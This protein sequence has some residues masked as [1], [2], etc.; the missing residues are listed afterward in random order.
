LPL[1]FAEIAALRKRCAKSFCA[2]I[3]LCYNGSDTLT[4]EEGIVKKPRTNDDV[5]QLES[6]IAALEQLLEERERERHEQVSHHERTLQELRASQ[7]RFE[8]VMQGTNDGIW[9]WNVLTN[10]VYFSPRWK[11]MLGYED[12]EIQNHFDEWEKRLHPADRERALA[13]VQDY[14]EGRT[15]SYELE[16]R[17]LHKDGTYRW[18]LAR[19]VALRDESGKPYRMAGSHV[20][21]TER[22]QMEEDLNRFFALSI[23]MLCIAG[24]DGYFKRLNPAWEKTLGWTNETMLA[25]PYME[26]VHP[27]DREATLAAARKIVDAGGEVVLFENRYLCKDGSY[28]WLVWNAAPLAGQQMIYAVAHDITE[29]KQAEQT[30]RESETRYRQIVEN[31][32]DVI[33][34]ADVYGRFTYANPVALRIIGYPETELMG[35]HYLDIVRPDYRRETERFYVKQL[36]T[37]TL[38]TYYE[39]P[40]ITKDG[41]EIWLGQN[42]QLVREKDRIVGVQSVARDITERRRME[43]ALRESQALYQSLVETLP[44]HI[45]CKDRDG[46]FTF[47]NKRWC[48]RKGRPIEDIVGK[49]DFDFHPKELAEKY[50]R[51]DQRVLETGTVL[52]AVEEQYALSGE[53][54]YIHILKAPIVND[55]GEIVGTQGM[56]WDVTERRRAEEALRASEERRR[57]IVESAYDAFIAMDADGLIIDWNP[58]AESTFGWSREEVLGRS[59]AETIIPPQHRE[60]HRRGLE[61]FLTTGKGHMTNQRIETTALHRAGHEFPVELTITPIRWGE[62]YI[63]SSFVHDIT[64]RKQ[65]EEELRKAKEAAEAANRAKSD[66]L[67]NVSHEIRTP[68]NGIIGMTELTLDTQLTP[69]QREYLNMVRESADSL[70][71]IINALLDFSKIEAGKLDLE[72]IEF[73]LRDSL[74]DTVRTLALRAHAKGLE[75]VCHVL[76]DVPDALVGDPGRLRQIV[77]NLV[78]NAIKFT[79]KG[80]V[81]VRAAVEGN[82]STSQWGNESVNLLTHELIDPLTHELVDPLTSSEVCLHFSVHDTGIGIPAEKQRLIFEAFTQADS[83]T[84][85]KYGGTGLGLTI[86]SQLVHMMRGRIWV[87]SAEGQGSVFHFTARFGLQQGVAQSFPPEP[88]NL[89]DLPV[90]VVDDNATNCRILGEILTNWRMKPTVVE[91]GAS[92]LAAM[93]EAQKAGEPFALV[94]LD[95]NMPEMDGFA[96]I[97]RIRQNAELDG[98]TIMMLSSADRSG[99]AARCRALGATYL[100]KPIKQSDLLDAVLTALGAASG[101]ARLVGKVVPLAD[102]PTPITRRLHVLLAEDHPVNQRL[103]TFMLEK[104]GHQVVV[105]G[106]GREALEA[107]ERQP[108]DVVLMDVHMPEMDGFAATAAIREKEKTT[109]DRV[110]II[111]MTAMVMKGDRERCLAVGMD[112]YVSKPLQAQELLD[113][114]ESASKPPGEINLDERTFSSTPPPVEMDVMDRATLMYRVG[115]SVELLK[116]IVQ[117]FLA[118]CPKRLSQ[119]REAVARGDSTALEHAAHAL[120]GSLGNLSAEAA[121]S[122]ASQLEMLAHESNVTRYAEAG[123]ALE[124]EVERLQPALE[125]LIKQ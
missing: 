56:Y 118:D 74:G 120:K 44:V 15:S 23:D 3:R 89:Q 110:P 99:D 7:E 78:G 37:R 25:K 10:E 54:V 63:F 76:S 72:P 93:E 57:L 55:R 27:E 38:N 65:A 87:E 67:A 36:R 94:L 5:N 12:H 73:L 111:A 122:A 16:H 41:Q 97:E 1:I 30:L 90:L 109:G 53:K 9:D 75:L 68:M 2:E 42:V 28:K 64:V 106:N 58:Q 115:G 19:G 62:R 22:K 34:R 80:E 101:R 114:V 51:D 116:E 71:D 8:L 32:N 13:T 45:Y 14:F 125:A 102:R 123:A 59:L 50:T 70:L 96:V 18:I 117:L 92:A 91:S 6:R 69:D 79:E 24:F 104:R 124:R 49:T 108:F 105:V 98:A 52:E 11:S 17:L 66:F 107:L 85:R 26:F 21:L 112:G 29:R 95:V 83:S 31:A 119:I 46:K 60:M 4:R 100:M 77:V 48:E 113:V 47:G 103:V 81:V 39:F 121:A 20:D 84:T 61:R 43:E 35:K 82:E 33:Y 88:L 86:S 40:V